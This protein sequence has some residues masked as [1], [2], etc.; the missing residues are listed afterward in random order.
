[1][2]RS[3]CTLTQPT[4]H[5][6]RPIP[7]GASLSPPRCQR[8]VIDPHRRGSARD[9]DSGSSASRTLCRRAD[10]HLERDPRAAEGVPR[11]PAHF[12]PPPAWSGPA[13]V[14]KR[15]P[16]RPDGARVTRNPVST[17]EAPGFAA[18]T[19]G[20]SKDGGHRHEVSLSGGQHVL[21]SEVSANPE[22][23]HARDVPKFDGEPTPRGDRGIRMQHAGGRSR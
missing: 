17:G 20:Y 21:T 12:T 15:W 11:P 3:V 5:M 14:V 23:C 6:R 8:C 9:H 7:F 18:L 19:Y 1:M 13:P 2:P 4:Q 10:G 22:V 16:A